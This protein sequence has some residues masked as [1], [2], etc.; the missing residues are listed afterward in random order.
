MCFGDAMWLDTTITH[1][2]APFCLRAVCV[3]ALIDVPHRSEI[4]EWKQIKCAICCERIDGRKLK[5]LCA[6]V[7]LGSHNS[8]GWAMHHTYRGLNESQTHRISNVFITFHEA[9]ISSTHLA[10]R[11]GIT[12]HCKRFFSPYFLHFVSGLHRCARSICFEAHHRLMCVSVAPH[13]LCRRSIICSLHG[14]ISQSATMSI[15]KL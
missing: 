12:F 5:N 3:F 2:K 7:W 4:K 13:A 1:T 9:S 8:D 6:V 11:K 14:N 10:R 15:L